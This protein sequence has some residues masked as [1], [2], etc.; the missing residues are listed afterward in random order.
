MLGGPLQAPLVEVSNAPREVYIALLSSTVHTLIIFNTSATIHTPNATMTEN[1][2][3]VIICGGGPV[4]LLLAFQL[5]RLGIPTLIIEQY[6]KTRQDMY[7]RASTLYPRTVEMLDQLDLLDEISQVGF[8]GKASVT[9]KD[10]QRV[11]DRGW[12]FISRVTDTYFD[13]CLN[14]RQ[15][16]SEDIFR[17][18]LEQ[19]GGRVNAG[20]TLKDLV[21]GDDGEDYRISAKM[22]DRNGATVTAKSKYIIGADG[23]RSSVRQL[24]GIPFIGE[25]SAFN[26]IRIDAVI[27]TDMPDSRIGFGAIESATHGNVLWVALDHGRSRIGFAVP[28]AL[29]EEYGDNITEEVAKQ[30]AIKAMAP[31]KIKFVEVEWWTLYSI[32]QRVAETFQYKDRVLLAGDAAHTHSSGAAQGMVSIGV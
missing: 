20:W 32:G 16:Y 22:T 14:I 4:G 5:A 27:E 15:K 7:G 17:S 2:Y 13:Y 21:I 3:D 26:W 10:G 18:A 12:D 6:D 31:F 19:Y 9:Y 28:K 23:G 29:H 11:H 24:A 30:E 8:I 25:K 1:L